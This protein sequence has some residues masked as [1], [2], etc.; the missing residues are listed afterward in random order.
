MP[1]HPNCSTDIL[2]GHPSKRVTIVGAPR[3]HYNSLGHAAREAADCQPCLTPTI[4][5][6]RLRKNPKITWAELT[7]PVHRCMQHK[8]GQNKA[9]RKQEMD[10]MI[11]A[12]DARKKDLETP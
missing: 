4:T 6:Q 1:R 5:Y 2:Y 12:M 11:K 10:D 7:E 3:P 8:T 9:K